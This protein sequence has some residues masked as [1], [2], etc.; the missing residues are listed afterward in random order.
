MRCPLG[1]FFEAG[2]SFV[3]ETV[4][5]QASCSR[6]SGTGWEFI[7]GEGVRACSCRTSQH[8]DALTNAARIP[9]R[10]RDCDLENYFALNESQ[11]LALMFAQRVVDEY[12]ALEF[13]LLILGPCGV[14]KTHLVVAIL[15]GLLRKG[16]SC[17]FADFRD[18]LKEIQES[19]N[20][21][22]QTSELRVLSPIYDAEVLVLDELGANKPTAWVQETMTQIINNRYNEKKVTIFTSN[23]PDA[24]VA[25]GEESLTDRVGV[26][27]RSRL[28]E[29][30]KVIN[31]SGEDYRQKV[32]Q[33]GYRF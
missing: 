21:I 18:L 32:R 6:C 14:G 19:Y 30:C 27:L 10:Y 15:K 24:A 25:S 1:S 5:A 28:F 20:P 23:Y 9:K 17:L 11:Q 22:S 16:I 29:M 26:R 31:I 3:S 4:I 13:G 7:E 8:L 33:A 12:P 2:S